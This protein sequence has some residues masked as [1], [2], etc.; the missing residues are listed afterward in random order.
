MADVILEQ[1]LNG[2]S[3]DTEQME[4]AIVKLQKNLTWILEHLD[5][6]N[7]QTLNT[8]QTEIKSEDGATRI[9]GAELVMRDKNGRL[10]VS[11]GKGAN[12][13]FHFRLFDESGEETLSLN[14]DGNAVF[15]GDIHGANIRGADIEGVNIRIA[16][17]SFRDYIA[18]E[19]N[20]V[21][22]TIGLYYGGTRVGGLR[23]LDAGAIE[24]FGH[25]ISIGSSS[26]KVSIASGA[27]GTFLTADKKTVT[28]EDGV[29]TEIL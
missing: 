1:D 19:N 6:K 14:E 25:K 5:S 27:S 26:G 13:E 3:G 11:I 4:T 22:D 7:V 8:N 9:N 29:V 20:G 17:N 15:K 28:V 10:R 23:T 12:G 2:F 21:E 18:L 24:L 16:P